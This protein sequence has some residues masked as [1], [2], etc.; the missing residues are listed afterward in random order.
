MEDKTLKTEVRL[1]EIAND[2]TK[3]D[4][5]LS[6]GVIIDVSE[7]FRYENKDEYVVKIKI[8]DESFN[9]KAY[10]ENP[11]IKFHKFVTIHVYSPFVNK[12]PKIKNVGDIIR[13]RRF[14]FVVTERGEMIG[15]LNMYSNW[16]IY[17]GKTGGKY[18][19]TSAKDI[20]PNEDRKLTAWEKSRLNE[21]RGWCSDFFSQNSIRNITW[22]SDLREPDDEDQA[23]KN[24]YTCEKVDL[25]L[26]TSKVQKEKKAIEFYDHNGKKY[27]LFLQAPPVLVKDDVIKLRCVNVLFTPEGRIIALTDNSSCLIVPDWFF[28][29]K[30]FTKSAKISPMIKTPSKFTPRKRSG[31]STPMNTK[32]AATAMF[33][34]LEDF[35]YEDFIVDNP[36]IKQKARK[37]QDTTVTLIKKNYVH[38]IPT[39]IAELFTILENPT[40]Y[41]H[42][43]FVVS[44]YILGFS[45]TKLSKIVK[46]MDVNS[47]KV[48]GFNE[49]TPASAN[50]KY[51]YHFILFMKDQSVEGKDKLLNTYVLTNE[52]DQNLFD[53]WEMLPKPEEASEWENLTKSEITVFENKF[54]GLKKLGNKVKLVVELLITNGGRPFFKL[55][56]TIFLP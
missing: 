24:K 52:G 48:Y 54:K 9:Y 23:A 1:A 18:K 12:C 25:I 35:E 34:F 56:D 55:Y 40:E 16:L 39:A 17:Q 22:S 28:D 14:N 27:A 30:L 37:N 47:K 53:L 50:L 41:E 29:A 42:Q 6:Y 45:E 44:G 46:K 32:R 43:R 26:K 10:I 3:R 51:I 20:V 36:S 13:L 49:K 2:V 5:H 15:Y 11:E 19:A 8:I 7:P 38:K 31:K 4:K 21:L 33:P